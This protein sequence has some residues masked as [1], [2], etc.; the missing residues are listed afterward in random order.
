MIFLAYLYDLP[1]STSGIDSIVN[2]MTTGSFYWLV[3]MILFF[4]FCLVFI[5]GIT[6]QRIKTGT[7]D[8]SAWAIIASMAT[9][10]P[11]LLFSVQAGYIRLDWLVIVVTLNIASAFWFFLDKK[12][13][14]VWLLIIQK[15]VTK[16]QYY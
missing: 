11:A 10:L 2:Q 12:V 5:G 1:N 14:E 4:T 6:R 13:T 16:L 3:P 15:S 9:L 8:Y 7:A